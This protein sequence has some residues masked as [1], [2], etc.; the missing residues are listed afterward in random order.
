MFVWVFDFL[1]FQKPCYFLVSFELFFH[2][3]LEPVVQLGTVWP[4]LEA[5]QMNSLDIPIAN[6]VFLLASGAALT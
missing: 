3:A 6:T 1:L 5:I 2:S 4:P